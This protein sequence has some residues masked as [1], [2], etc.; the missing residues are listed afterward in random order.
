[1]ELL[2]HILDSYTMPHFN[3]NEQQYAF[4]FPICD[5]DNH[6]LC[7]SYL[8]RSSIYNYSVNFD[9]F[10]AEHMKHDN[11]NHKY[12]ILMHTIFHWQ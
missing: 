6:A 11:Q 8:N 1:M 3:A 2:I 7:D 4:I 5:F 9:L 12:G 10:N